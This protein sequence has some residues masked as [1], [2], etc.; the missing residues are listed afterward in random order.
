MNMQSFLFVCLFC[1][2]LFL[3][4]ENNLYVLL[5]SNMNIF[6]GTCPPRA[7]GLC[8]GSSVGCELPNG[9]AEPQ[10]KCSRECLACSWVLD[11]S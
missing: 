5:V 4:G 1:F 10:V 7:E 2:V 3:V 8:S 11:K 9:A 6:Y